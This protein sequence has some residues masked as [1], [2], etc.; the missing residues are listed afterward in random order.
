MLENTIKTLTIDDY[1]FAE[2]VLGETAEKRE[3]GIQEILQWYDDNPKINGHRDRLTILYFLR[4]AKFNIEKAK[5]KIK[6][7]E[8]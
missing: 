7:F 5:K 3:T 1:K 8:S 6:R 2:E 4:G